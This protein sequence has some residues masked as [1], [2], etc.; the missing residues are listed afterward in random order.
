[1]VMKSNRSAFG[2]HSLQWSLIAIVILALFWEGLAQRGMALTNKTIASEILAGTNQY[3]VRHGLPK[4]YFHPDL[5]KAAELHSVDMA[6]KNYFSHR[7]P[8]RG[9]ERVRHRV[10]A[11]RISPRRVAENIATCWGFPPT[12]VADYSLT[13]WLESP[14][15]LANSS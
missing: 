7:S 2:R 10:E 8:T 14:G 9:L 5:T 12:Q 11:Q 4:L 13:S 3:R 6:N 15:H 1:M